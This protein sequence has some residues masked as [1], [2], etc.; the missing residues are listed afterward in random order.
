MVRLH[1]WPMQRNG[2]LSGQWKIHFFKGYGYPPFA[3]TEW[4]CDNLWLKAPLPAPGN[5]D[6]LPFSPAEKTVQFMGVFKCVSK[7]KKFKGDPLPDMLLAFVIT[8][9]GEPGVFADDIEI[10]V[11]NVSWWSLADIDDI[12]HGNFQVYCAD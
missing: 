5:T 3:D 10:Q 12:E 7:N 9:S 1:T 8:D 4:Q 2:S 6:F 11:W